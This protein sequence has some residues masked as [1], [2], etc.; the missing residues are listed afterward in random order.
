MC[1]YEYTNIYIYMYIDM[2]TYGYVG[3][4]ISH[5]AQSHDFRFA[6]FGLKTFLRLRTRDTRSQARH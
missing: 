3:N 6:T 4:L 1:I 5:L 2:Y